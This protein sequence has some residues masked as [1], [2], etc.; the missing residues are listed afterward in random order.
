MHIV[1]QRAVFHKW[2]NG[3]NSFH[4]L[5]EDATFMLDI[6]RGV[7]TECRRRELIFVAHAEDCARFLLLLLLAASHLWWETMVSV[8]VTHNDQ[9]HSI[10]MRT[11]GQGRLFFV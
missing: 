5:G 11:L 1:H 10:R 6:P 2:S 8:R 9:L 7:E 4:N 3:T